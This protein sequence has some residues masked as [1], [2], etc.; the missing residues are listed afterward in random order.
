MRAL[1]QRVWRLVIPLALLVGGGVAFGQAPPD[2]EVEEPPEST[3]PIRRE[4]LPSA[5]LQELADRLVSRERALER[6]EEDLSSRESDLRAAESRIE[7]RLE[8]LQK[9][10]ES[11]EEEVGES[12]TELEERIRS[13]VK[14]FEAMR[15][16][17]SAA[18]MVE[19][20][21]NE[22]VRVLNRMNRT[23]AGKMLA[24][25]PPVLAARLTE[26]MTTPIVLEPS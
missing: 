3:A 17:D 10:R 26:R 14:M 4:E 6:R 11:F 18:V 12:D 19:L 20:D 21:K 2:D 23:K 16:K 24:A 5:G 13:V 15:S 8:E 1:W 9:L 22:A 7:L 25:M